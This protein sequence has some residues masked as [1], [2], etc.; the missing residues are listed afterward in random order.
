MTLRRWLRWFLPN[1]AALRVGFYFTCVSCSLAL[2]GAR[3]VRADI[4][5]LGLAAGRQLSQLEDL[6]GDAEVLLVN[7]A[8]FHHATSYTTQSVSNVLDRFERECE[9]NPGMLAQGLRAVPP[10]AMSRLEGQFPRSSRNAIIRDESESGGMLVCF[11][12]AKP[13]TLHELRMRL[14]HFSKTRDLAEFGNL[15][16]T[17]VARKGDRSRV[18]TLWTD[19]KLDL[20]RMFPASGDAAGSDSKLAPRPPNSRRTFTAGAVGL[21]F[22]LRIYETTQTEQQIQEFYDRAL[23]P[24]GFEVPQG[25]RA[26]GTTAYT[27]RQGAQVFVSV[28]GDGDK[29]FVTLTDAEGRV[30]VATAAEVTP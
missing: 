28:N 8:R 21:P 9:R 4:G 7:G 6:T 5:E 1:R 3:A 2:L 18:I 19:S 11:V 10:E 12:G 16:Y 22:S 13:G 24:R 29:R 30:G 20:G 23:S 14:Q 27:D 26:S 17:Y 25:A 15:R